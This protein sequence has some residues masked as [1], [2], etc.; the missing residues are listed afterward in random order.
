MNFL[1]KLGK[2]LMLPVS[3]LPICGI[4]M[5]IGYF[6][7]PAAMQGGRV[8]GIVPTI[9]FIL[10]KAGG[11][12]IDNMAW[13][14]VIG[15]AVGMSDDKNGAVCLAGL[16]SWF[17]VITLLSADTVSVVVPGM[18]EA[19]AN[20]LAFKKIQNPF[21]AIICGLLAAGCYNRF[22][23]TSLPDYLAFFSGRRFVVIVTALLSVVLAAVL[24]FIWPL[25]FSALTNFGK[26]ILSLGGLGAG[27]Y[28]FFNRLLIAF[29][30]HHALNNVFWF[31]TIGLGD[32]TSFWAGKTSADVGW[33][34]GMYMSGF[35]PCMMFGIWGAALAMLKNA[36]H[37]EKAKAILFSAAICAF[38][39]GVTEPFEFM[40]M[41][42]AFPLYVV[43]AL[44]YG[45]FTVIVYYAGFRAGFSFSA[46][47]VDLLFSS[48]LPAAKNIWLIIPLGISAFIVFYLVF[49]F[50]IK[51]F[52]FITPGRETDDEAAAAPAAPSGETAADDKAGKL[53]AAIGGRQ[54]IIGLDCCATRLRLELADSAA[55]D[56]KACRAAGALG[57]I[58][59]GARSCQVVIGV[60][61]QGVCDDMKKLL[62]CKEPDK[63][64]KRY[65]KHT[66][67]IVG[68]KEAENTYTITDA[69][70]M[71]A[72]PAGGLA[73]IL[74]SFRSDVRI[75]A[76]GRE[77][78]AKSILEI[79]SLGIKEGDTVEILASGEDSN[80]ATIAGMNYLRENL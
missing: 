52:N 75:K 79:M 15:T 78:D 34:L 21:L 54:N 9:G 18:T 33:D 49:D 4:L 46:G 60:T 37:K 36:T 47:A 14:F 73:A 56:E 43:Y 11:A 61:V 5:G 64:K 72:R 70:G 28:A 2:S 39:C 58:I 8:E 7:S 69:A 25:V 22:R 42:I 45:I 67:V 27:I 66:E 3:V 71:H 6:L 65:V 16:V 77:A 59:T 63:K 24:A 68:A 62:A 10:I 12:V 13:L 74:K 26:A 57:V 32:L 31:D 30:L 44:L 17:V 53:I 35:F 29:G 55:V 1:Q 23:E 19:S 76:N 41:Y 20:Y 48:S 40:F 50:M 38:I 80:E 51:R